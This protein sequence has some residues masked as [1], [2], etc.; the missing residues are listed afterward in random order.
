MIWFPRFLSFAMGFLSLSQEILWVRLGGFAYKGIPQ[1]F[2]FVL[3]MYLLGIMAGAAIGKRYCRGSINLL[4]VSGWIL[5]F[6]GLLDLVLPWL[7]AWSLSA[8]WIAGLAVLSG[9]LIITAGFKSVVF[10]IAHHLGSSA[11]GGI[12]TSV[13]KVYFANI[14]GS[15]VGPLVT[16]FVLM[17]LMPVQHC[18]T[19]MAALTLVVSASCFLVS[20]PRLAW[21]TVAFAGA[22]G[23]ALLVPNLLLPHVARVTNDG[24]PTIENV[25]ENRSGII[26]T[27]QT[28]TGEM[29]IY[30]GNVYDGT[31]NTDL[32]RDSNGISRTYLAAALHPAPRR[33]LVIGLSGGAWAKVL[34]GL[35][36][37]EHFDFVEINP[38]YAELIHATSKP[39][40]DLLRDPRV[41]LRFDDGRRW[42]KRHPDTRYDLIV[43][44]TTFHWRAYASLLL[45]HDF[46]DLVR[47][48]LTDDGIVA[49]NSTGSTDAFKT[50]SVVFPHVY[51]F[52]NFVYA[53]N[54]DLA[55]QLPMVPSRLTAL[56]WGGLRLLDQSRA[57]VADRVKLLTTNTIRFDEQAESRRVGRPLK[58][59]TEQ[60][61]LTEYRYGA[62]YHGL[63]MKGWP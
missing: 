4:R 51:R 31:E 5:L 9:S 48:H 34:M 18:L 40:P 47:Q 3:S 61:M 63:F 22:A 36:S 56:S 21:P 24:R 6:A 7:F 58:V 32:V 42:L 17:D 13:S 46:L 30:G 45:S 2:A 43:M 28:P 14:L 35:P 57:E 54:R 59:I 44:N 39:P 26:H 53:S 62:Y 19:F 11:A 27:F 52:R 10:P 41:S 37:V 55:P 15:T 60:N 33:V 1:S 23:A 29:V 20:A 8:G 38:G 16:G 49:Y 12:G 25:I 50:A